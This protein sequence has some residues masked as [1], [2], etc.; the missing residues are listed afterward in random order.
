[1]SLQLNCTC[2][3]HTRRKHEIHNCSKTKLDFSLPEEVVSDNG[4]LCICQEFADFLEQNGVKHTLVPPYHPSS[5]ETAEHTV[6]IVC[7]FFCDLMG[8]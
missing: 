5:N 4:I 6:W 7:V 3:W 2:E 1:M 8:F